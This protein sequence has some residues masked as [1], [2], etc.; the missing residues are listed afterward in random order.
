MNQDPTGQGHPR[1]QAAGRPLPGVGLLL[2][3]WWWPLLGAAIGLAAGL[4]A[5]L[6]L[7]P[8]YESTAIVTVSTADPNDPVDPTELSRAAQALARLA[9]QPGVVGGPLR[10][11]GLPEVADDPRRHVLVQAAPDAPIIRVSGT[12]TDPAAAR[13]IATTISG[14]LVRFAPFPPFQATVAAPP[15]RSTEPTAPGW[16]RK[17][18]A[19]ALGAGVALVLAATVPAGSRH[20]GRRRRTTAGP[21]PRSS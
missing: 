14:A 11:A 12:S 1:A 5:D 4:G 19:T 15:E 10:E 13:R 2:G 17:A 3:R 16:A 18:G 9:T 7:E 20:D 21:A 8:Q 6:V